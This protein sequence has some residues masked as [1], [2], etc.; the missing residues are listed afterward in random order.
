[1]RR[2][3]FHIDKK[4]C[5]GS[6]FTLIKKICEGSGFTLIKKICKGSGFTLMNKNVKLWFHIDTNEQFTQTRT[7]RK[8][9]RKLKRNYIK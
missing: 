3:W 2:V 7:I 4:K 5:E 8:L 6:G 1:M 9:H